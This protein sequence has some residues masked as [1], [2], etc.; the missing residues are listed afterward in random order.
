MRVGPL[1]SLCLALG[2]TSS[3]CSETI[4]MRYSR[5]I[6]QLQILYL[7]CKL[8]A[9]SSLKCMGMAAWIYTRPGGSHFVLE[10]SASFQWI[11]NEHKICHTPFLNHAACNR[12]N[13]V[14]AV[15]ADSPLVQQSP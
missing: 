2:F 5:G 6:G 9:K 8:R 12:E 14:I 7:E 13:Y 10:S 3:S 15:K 11:E 1:T 4:L